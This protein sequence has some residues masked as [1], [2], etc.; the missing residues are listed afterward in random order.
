VRTKQKIFTSHLLSEDD[1]NA[2]DWVRELEHYGMNAKGFLKERKKLAR[3]LGSDVPSKEAIWSLL[4]I[5]VGKTKDI[6]ALG[7]IYCDMAV[8]L[9]QEGKDFF[10]PL[11][12]SVKMKLL[13]LEGSVKKV[14]I[15]SGGGCEVCRKLDGKK[16]S[17][18]EALKKMPIPVRECENY[19]YDAK[20]GFCRCT[21]VGD[22]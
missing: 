22:M 11:Q 18:E 21:Y 6:Q 20:Q 19:L 17:I 9:N 7:Q 3:K 2:V 15:M 5:L 16:L 10:V 8:F 12:Q 4:N 14:E 13:W 1:A